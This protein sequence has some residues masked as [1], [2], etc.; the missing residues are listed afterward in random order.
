MEFKPQRNTSFLEREPGF[1]RTAPRVRRSSLISSKA[2]IILL[3][4]SLAG[5][6]TIAKD[7]Q[8]YRGGNFAH[9]SS[10]STKMNVT[11]TPVVLGSAPSERVTRAAV[12]KPRPAARVRKE[13]EAP[14]VEPVGLLLSVR[15]RSPPAFFSL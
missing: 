12:E 14:P 8:Y 7:G 6:A 15:H 9:Q 3:L 5:L 13:S 11:S 4:L 10:L 1:P 2:A